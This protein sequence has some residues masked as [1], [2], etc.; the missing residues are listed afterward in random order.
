MEKARSAIQRSHA[1]LDSL[2]QA[3]DDFNVRWIIAGSSAGRIDFKYKYI[4]E[5]LANAFASVNFA[6]STAKEMTCTIPEELSA[7]LKKYNLDESVR[8]I[9]PYRRA[10]AGK[11]NR[12]C[13]RP[14][15]LLNLSKDSTQFPL[16]Y[17]SVLKRWTISIPRILPTQGKKSFR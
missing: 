6:D 1:A 7:R 9:R 10:T 4:I 11:T 13:F 17:Y 14:S 2:H 8:N 3:L 16:P 12:R 5:A 15:S